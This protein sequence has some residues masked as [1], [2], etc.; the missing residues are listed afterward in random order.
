MKEFSYN[1]WP[2]YTSVTQRNLCQTFYFYVCL[3]KT[4]D[5]TKL[6]TGSCIISSLMSA[7]HF[8]FGAAFYNSFLASFLSSSLLGLDDFSPSS[9]LMF[10]VFLVSHLQYRTLNFTPLFHSFVFVSPVEMCVLQ[11]TDKEGSERLLCSVLPWALLHGISPHMC[12]G[13]WCPHAPR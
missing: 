5:V 8:V 13:S 2:C 4:H 9:L 7:S 1:S 12:S 6:S 10:F 3:N 11:E